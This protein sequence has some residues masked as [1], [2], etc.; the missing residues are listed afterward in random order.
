MVNEDVGF[1]LLMDMFND[2]VHADKESHAYLPVVLSFARH[3]AEDVA[4][5]VPRSNRLMALQ[6]GC[7][8][9]KSEVRERGVCVD[10]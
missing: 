7:V 3:C 10:P 2:V 5:I 1:S 6:Y 4:G 8:V 9:P